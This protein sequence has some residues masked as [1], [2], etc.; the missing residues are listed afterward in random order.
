MKEPIKINTKDVKAFSPLKERAHTKYN[1][2]VDKYTK[3]NEPIIEL[4]DEQAQKFKE[5][6]TYCRLNRKCINGCK[7]YINLRNFSSNDDDEIRAI[8]AECLNYTVDSS[9]QAKEYVR[10]F[11]KILEDYG[12][13]F[14]EGFPKL[15]KH[16]VKGRWCKDC[17]AH[18]TTMEF[19]DHRDD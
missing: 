19:F 18:H 10:W 17:N 15:M 4:N 1:L 9:F 12:M 5:F 13:T 11:N 14:K 3:F 6:E 8:C 7:G 2:K 16:E